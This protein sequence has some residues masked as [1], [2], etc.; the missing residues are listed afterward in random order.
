[1][2]ILVCLALP[3]PFWLKLWNSNSATSPFTTTLGS[4]VLV[5]NQQLVDLKAYFVAAIKLSTLPDS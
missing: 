5:H 1:M 3:L 4:R 2:N